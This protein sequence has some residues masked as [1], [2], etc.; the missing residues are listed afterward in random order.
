MLK[1][2]EQHVVDVHTLASEDAITV[3]HLQNV[4]K[5]RLLTHEPT[6]LPQTLL[7]LGNMLLEGG[8]LWESLGHLQMGFVLRFYKPVLLD[9]AYDG[10]S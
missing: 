9:I 6:T 4:F 3:L 7:G 5:L 8:R 1:C 10:W 2:C